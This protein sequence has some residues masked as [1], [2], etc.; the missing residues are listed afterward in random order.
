MVGCRGWLADRQ[1]EEE[2][3]VDKCPD[4]KGEAHWWCGV[5]VGVGVGGRW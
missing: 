2:A 5:G 4:R 3:G 1:V